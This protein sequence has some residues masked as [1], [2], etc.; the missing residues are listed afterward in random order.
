MTVAM[1]QARRTG[2][3]AVACAST[4]NTSASLA[5]YAAQAGIPGARLRP[6]GQGRRGQ[7]RADARLRRAR[8]SLVRGNFDDCLAL[9][10]EASPALG[11][12]LLNSVNPFRLEGQKTIVFELL[13]QLGWDAPDW[14]AL[15]AGN[16]G[17][18]S[19]FGKALREAHAIGLI[20][21]M[22]RIAGDS[23]ERRGAVRAR[24]FASGFRERLGCEPETVATAIRIGAPASWDR[25][26]RAIRETSGVVRRRHRRRDP[27][28]EAGH[29]R[30]RRRLRAGERGE[31]GRRRASC[32]ATA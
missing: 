31:R 1:T 5:A 26:V 27:R 18:T 2:A 21:R 15:P 24:A 32:V 3:R 25:A 28:G 29:R 22:P 4:G 10:R 9:A 6:R 11:I 20:D 17:N 19:A 30:G 12:Y 13:E 8:R 23:G 16:L 14:I 7:A